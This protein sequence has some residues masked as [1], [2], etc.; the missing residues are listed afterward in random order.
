MMQDE[1]T[2][3]C[4]MRTILIVS[5]M[6]LAARRDASLGSLFDRLLLLR[7]VCNV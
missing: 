3:K 4:N 2:L 6:L 5:L 7:A 1:V